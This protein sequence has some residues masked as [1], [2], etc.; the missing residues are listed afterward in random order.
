MNTYSATMLISVPVHYKALGNSII[1][2]NSLKIAFSSA[3]VLDKSDG[4]RFFDQ[5]GMGIIEIYGSTETG[6]IASRCRSKG[7]VS[8]T[9]FEN[10]DVKIRN[11]RIHVRSDF[12]SPDV[13]RDPDG[14]F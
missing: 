14:F 9:P 11:K 2:N 10:V 6:G 4:S 7:E 12:I 13:I 1:R 3:G 5:T 8:F